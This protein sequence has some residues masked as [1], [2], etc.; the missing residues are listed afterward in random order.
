MKIGVHGSRG[1]EKRKYIDFRC[2][3]RKRGK[4]KVLMNRTDGKFKTETDDCEESIS[5]ELDRVLKGFRCVKEMIS[6]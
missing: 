3:R 4:P 6:E 2:A 1:K 5:Y